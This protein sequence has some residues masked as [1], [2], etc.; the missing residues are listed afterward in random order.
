MDLSSNNLERNTPFSIYKLKHLENLILTHFWWCIELAGVIPL[1]LSQLPNLNIL[2][3]V[4]V[5][6]GTAIAFG[7]FSGA[8]IIAKRREH[9]YLGGLLSSGLSFFS[10][11]SLL[12]QSLVTPVPPSFKLLHMLQPSA[13]NG[14][15]NA[16]I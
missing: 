5:F 7:C 10:G 12:L 15:Q 8:A 16:G 1:T 4:T 9:L 13:E 14:V 2:I 3:L 6:V 11:C